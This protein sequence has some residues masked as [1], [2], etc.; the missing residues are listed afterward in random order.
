MQ[1]TLA[2]RPAVNPEDLN[3]TRILLREYADYLNRSL[4][5]EHICLASYEQE[6]AQ[7]PGLYCSPQG[8][9]LLAFVG[10]KPAGCVALKPLKPE[11]ALD[12]DG[13]ACEMK[14]LWVRS[15]FRGLSIGL[16]L[17]EELIEYARRQ[18]YTSVYL[19]TIPAAMQSANRIYQKL[20]F[21]AVER[22]TINPILGVNPAVGVEFYRLRIDDTPPKSG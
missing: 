12:L 13:S 5:E 15:E 22:Y 18:G 21:Q 9:I 1:T 14:R 16:A 17:V 10:A 20:G 4:G 7:L 2:I 8:V 3:V 11:R 19:D 6:L